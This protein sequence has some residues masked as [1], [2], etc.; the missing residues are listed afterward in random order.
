MVQDVYTS[1][2]F[3]DV[4]Y[5]VFD[6]TCDF[7][8]YMRGWVDAGKPADAGTAASILQNTGYTLQASKLVAANPGAAL[9]ANSFT[10][11]EVYRWWKQLTT[12]DNSYMS[13]PNS[14]P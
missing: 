3:N 12:G 1:D 14:M 8:T 4:A 2:A 9:V 10:P 6:D 11:A 5:G 13:G 7:D